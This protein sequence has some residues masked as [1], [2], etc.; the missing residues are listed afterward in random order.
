M[1]WRVLIVGLILCSWFQMILWQV[2]TMIHRPNYPV[3]RFIWFKR[4]YV[5]GTALYCAIII[6]HGGGNPTTF[7]RI[8][9]IHSPLSAAAVSR[10]HFSILCIVLFDSN[11]TMHGSHGSC[12]K[13][14]AQRFPSIANV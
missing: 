2:D 13:G 1:V 8:Q 11:P 5:D 4:F 14:R 6:L 9:L 3:G 10:N 12:R 7:T